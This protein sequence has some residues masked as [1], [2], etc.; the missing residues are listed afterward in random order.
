[1]FFEDL[2]RDTFGRLFGRRKTSEGVTS[3]EQHASPRR[4]AAQPP[5]EFAAH[6]DYADVTRQVRPAPPRYRNEI[7]KYALHRSTVCAACGR[8]AEVCRYEVHQRPEALARWSAR[9]LPLHRPDLRRGGRFVPPQC[10]RQAL[11]I[12]ASPASRR[13]AI[14]VGPATCC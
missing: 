5:E 1:M 3:G 8:C 4:P 10:P 14:A 13:W 6:P 2:E 11:S 9:G 12:T 7:G